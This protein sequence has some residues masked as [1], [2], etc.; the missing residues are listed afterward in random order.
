MYVIY[1][2]CLTLG[3]QPYFSDHRARDSAI[4]AVLKF[5]AGYHN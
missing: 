4:L 3:R 1:S 5:G 2:L